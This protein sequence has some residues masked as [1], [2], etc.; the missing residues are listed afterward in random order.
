MKKRITT[1]NLPTNQPS[2]IRKKE[3][4]K[5]TTDQLTTKNNASDEE[6]SLSIKI[7]RNPKTAYALGVWPNTERKKRASPK[8]DEAETTKEN[9]NETK[10]KEY[11]IWC[12]TKQMK[13]NITPTKKRPKPNGPID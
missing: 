10:R 13:Q 8:L 5:K 9:E 12:E 2:T 6:T 7:R 11:I 4:N 3:E 1:K